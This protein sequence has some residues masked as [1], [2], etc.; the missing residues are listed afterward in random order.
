MY[1]NIYFIKVHDPQ[2]G[3]YALSHIHKHLHGV[4]HCK[5]CTIVRFAIC[6]RGELHFE[7]VYC[8][9]HAY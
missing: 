4:N 5:H 8:M 7:T 6:C 1:P 9:V 2:A 3:K